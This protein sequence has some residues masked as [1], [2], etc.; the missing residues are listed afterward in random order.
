MQATPRGAC[1]TLLSRCATL[2]T[3]VA[4]FPLPGPAS[5]TVSPSWATA[6]CCSALSRSNAARTS[7]M[8]NKIDDLRESLLHVARRL[9]RSGDLRCETLSEASL[10]DYVIHQS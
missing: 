5:T 1:T 2:T 3:R 4:V 10:A 7:C 9:V 6:C 8:R